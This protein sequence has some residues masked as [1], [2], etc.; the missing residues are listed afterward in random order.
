MATTIAEQISNRLAEDIING[1]FVPGQKLEEQAIAERFEVSRT[2]VRDAFKQLLSTGLIESRPHRGVAVVDLELDQLNDLFEA[3]GEV[4]AICARLSAQRMNIVERK[5]LENLHLKEAS[6]LEEKADRVYF[7]YNEQV[8][9]AIHKGAHNKALVEIAQDLRR[10]LSPF[11]RSM[12]FTEGNWPDHTSMEH[13]ELIS[14]ILSGD[15]NKAY[16][17]MSDHVANSALNAITYLSE[18]RGE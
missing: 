18:T 17:E 12:F 11:R 8:H 16:A 9:S 2:P 7:D 13:D 4:E 14:A 1:V 5:H 10:R 6:V 3:L 15:M